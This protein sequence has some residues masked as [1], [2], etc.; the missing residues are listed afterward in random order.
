MRKISYTRHRFPPVII[1]RAIWLYFRFPLSF[2]DV[3]EMLAERGIDVSYETVR[4][5]MLKF[6]PAFAANIK[7]SRPRPSGTWHLDEVFVRIGGKRTYLWRAVDDEGEVLEVLAQSRR[8]KHAALKLMR[9]LL[10]KQGYIPNVIVTD[11]L[12][13]YAAALREL[14]LEHLHVTGGRLNN[15]AE[16]SHQP[17]RRRERRMGRFKSSGSMQRFLSVHDAIYN[18]FNLQRHLISR[19]ILRQMRASEYVAWNEIVTA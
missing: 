6:G 2:R 4:R 19:P 12:G 8:N 15:R 17:T 5:W 10:K 11:K 3:E 18:H 14:G 13:S 1:Q 9:K 7:A 16:V